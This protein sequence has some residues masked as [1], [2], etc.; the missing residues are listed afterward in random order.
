MPPLMP[1]TMRG[2]G[3]VAPPIAKARPKA[4]RYFPGKATGEEVSS[5]SEEE[6]EQD[7]A[8][9][10]ND[11]DAETV[12]EEAFV[13]TRS[14]AVPE[15]AIVEPEPEAASASEYE[16]DEEGE[17]GADS[18]E[19]EEEP[20]RA[21]PKPVFLSKTQRT[22]APTINEDTLQAQE[23]RKA[24]SRKRIEGQ[25]RLEAMQKEQEALS[26]EEGLAEVDDTDDLDP[27][28]EQ[29]AWRLREL[30]RIQRERQAIEAREAEREE[31]ERR[32]ALPDEERLAED[33]KRV[34]AEKAEQAAKRGQ[35]GFMQKYY[36]KG[37]FYQE[38][39]GDRDFSAPVESEQVDKMALPKMM[40]VR[41][42][43]D[44]GK[45]SRSKYTHLGD[46]DTSRGNGTWQVSGNKRILS[47]MGG[48]K[49]EMDKRKRRPQ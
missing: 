27:E 16:T 39:L 31:M 49:D 30:Q 7:E 11:G 6:D 32:L 4:A 38:E 21:L 29:Q 40:Q 44:V 1:I 20:R 28:A 3:K 24:E 25:I 43:D 37:A 15:V 48:M 35:M 5:G 8:D 17:S 10:Q 34:E 12:A 22:A 14:R 23:K 2:T 9:A 13:S 33:L 36:H 19:S 26:K 46:Q 47:Q 45:R 18:S 42:L 41:N